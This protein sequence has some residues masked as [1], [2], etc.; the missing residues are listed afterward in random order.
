MDEREKHIAAFKLV[1]IEKL[2]AAGVT[3][4]EAGRAI[5]AARGPGGIL[6]LL[7]LDKIVGGV[8]EVAEKAW[9]IGSFALPFAGGA[10]GLGGGMM[11]EHLLGPN[12][13]D[14]ANKRF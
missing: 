9:D 2:A 7:A 14:V 13:A 8:G 4:G 1:A 3:P 6:G 10:A 12:E 11:A 5:K